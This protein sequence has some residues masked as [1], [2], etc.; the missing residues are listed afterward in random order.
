MHIY[1]YIYIYIYICFHLKFFAASCAIRSSAPT[2]AAASWCALAMCLTADLSSLIR[3]RIP[4]SAFSAMAASNGPAVESRLGPK[5]GFT[6]TPGKLL[7]L[8]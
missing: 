3:S 1:V 5:R 8:K 6:V 4:D 7:T 2:T